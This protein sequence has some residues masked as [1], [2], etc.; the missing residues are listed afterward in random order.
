MLG[1][2]D[3]LTCNKCGKRLAVYICSWCKGRG[4]K[5]KFL[6]FKRPCRNCKGTRVVYKC[7]DWRMHD[8]EQ[9]RPAF[10]VINRYKEPKEQTKKLC[11]TCG[12]TRGIITHNGPKGGARTI[13]CP[14]CH[15]KGFID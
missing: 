3:A 12:G 7:P 11:P 1:R 10:E 2:E 5:R 15:G 8:Y 9:L 4:T 6:F 13:G 14:R